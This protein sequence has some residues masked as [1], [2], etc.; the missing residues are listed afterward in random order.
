MPYNLDQLLSP[1]A[2]QHSRVGRGLSHET[3]RVLGVLQHLHGILDDNIVFHAREFRDGLCD[4][5]PH[6][7]EV[8]CSE[9]WRIEVEVDNSEDDAKYIT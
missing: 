3:Y 7:Y 6:D 4:P 1:P 9:Q 2:Q 5:G 8:E